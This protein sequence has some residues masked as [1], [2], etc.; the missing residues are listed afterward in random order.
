MIVN[1]ILVLQDN[2]CTLR[3]L[4]QLD[5]G[6]NQ[7]SSLPDGFGNLNQ[8]Q[9]LDL[10]SNQLTTIPVSFFQLKQLKWLDVKHN[11]LEE[12]IV[13]VAGPCTDDSECRQCARQ[14]QFIT[15]IGMAVF[16]YKIAHVPDYMK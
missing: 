15:Q 12:E 5:L 11:P 8:L 7:L 1:L 16:V 6:K 3:H 4:A 9:K 14:V 10:Y 2:F 13:A